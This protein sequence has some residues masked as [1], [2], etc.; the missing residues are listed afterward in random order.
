MNIVIIGCGK[1]GRRLAAELDELGHDVAVVDPDKQKFEKLGEDF[2]GLCVRGSGIDTDVLK[3]AGCD[4]ADVAVVI[5]NSDNFNIMSAKI[6][7]TFF[8][9]NDVYVR[10]FD[11]SREAVFRKFGLCTVCSTRI[12]KDIFMSLILGTTNEIKPVNISGTDVGFNMTR[13]D[14]RHSGKS[15]SAIFC[16]SGEMLFAVKK[17]NGA[18]FLAN[19]SNLTVEEG[20]MLVYALI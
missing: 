15:P 19:E 4:N 10:V 18:V 13:A 2:G 9:I 3:E 17:Q 5:T 1:T 16:K 20:D 8:G 11:S 14:K 7:T 12:E 6:L